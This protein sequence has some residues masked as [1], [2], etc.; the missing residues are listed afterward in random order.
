[1]E[2]KTIRVLFKWIDG[3]LRLYGLTLLA[4]S[5]HNSQERDGTVLFHLW[6]IVS[7]ENIEDSFSSDL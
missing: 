3:D 2:G 4:A 5:S 1:M 6:I 7:V